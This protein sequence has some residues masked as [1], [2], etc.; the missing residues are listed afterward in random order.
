MN[1]QQFDKTVGVIGAGSFG[2]AISMLLSY[3]VNVLL[4]SR[5]KELVEAI[6]STRE[7]QGIK[8]SSNV[9]AT[10]DLSLI[11]KS[12]QLIF[13]IVPSENFRSMMTRLGP[14]L[15]PYH[16]LIHGTKGLDMP[17]DLDWDSP[18]FRLKRKEVN[19]MSEVIEQESIVRRIGCLSGPNLAK[20]IL[21]GQPTATVVA[22][23]YNEVIQQVQK[24]LRSK[25]FYI[26][27]TNDILG[28]ELAGALKNIIAIGTGILTGKGF[29][30]NIQ[31]ILI[32]RGLFEMIHFGKKMGAEDEK[33]FLGTAGIA[34]LI[35]TATSPD[36]RNFTFGLQLGKGAKREAII[37][38]MPE[39]AEGLRTLKITYH[40]AKSFKLRVP[41]METLYNVVFENYDISKGIDYLMTYPYGVDVDFI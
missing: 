35:A 18:D 16:M 26:F 19:T 24:V 34:D 30:K 25:H 7:N 41:I 36:S 29:G 21:E 32:N 28:A 2:T 14:H 15:R 37:E 40:L 5:K 3:N 39:L 27:G 22:S 9:V 31:S 12:C 13:P 33:A 23:R 4:Y 17:K 20:E 10:D 38:S 8:L 1:Q 6:N 11:A